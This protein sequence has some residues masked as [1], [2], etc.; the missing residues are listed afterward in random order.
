MESVGKQLQVVDGSPV[1][2]LLMMAF[3]MLTHKEYFYKPKAIHVGICSTAIHTPYVAVCFLDI[4]FR[5]QLNLSVKPLHWDDKQS[6][7]FQFLE[8]RCPSFKVIWLLDDQE[9]HHW[10]LWNSCDDIVQIYYFLS[11]QLLIVRYMI[12]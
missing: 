9:Q 5:V 4:L 8:D 11:E 10:I 6:W 1:K 12:A 3:L 7:V 2:T